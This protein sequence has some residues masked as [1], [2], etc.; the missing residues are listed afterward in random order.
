MTTVNI[1]LHFEGNCEEAFRFYR[2]VFGGEFSYL[3]RYKEM[4]LQEGAKPFSAAEGEKLMHVSLPISKET[5]LIG[6]D[7]MGQGGFV[8]KTGS[9]FSI[10]LS[11]DNKAEADRLYGLLA[12][13][14][15]PMMPMAMMFWGD[16]YGMLV[17]KFGINWMVDVAS[18]KLAKA[19]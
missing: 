10:M 18:D 14:G 6:N 13:G 4:P 3:G 8:T 17:D 12:K 2:S 11:V 7:N 16:Y 5:M 19:K 9:G 1:N 15:K